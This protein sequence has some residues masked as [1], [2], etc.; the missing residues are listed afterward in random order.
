MVDKVAATFLALVSRCF[1]T[2]ELVIAIPEKD[3]FVVSIASRR[4]FT[5][6]VSI[7]LVVGRILGHVPGFARTSGEVIRV[8]FRLFFFLVAADENE[9]GNKQD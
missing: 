6:W 2:V 3:D 4:H 9:Y 8:C 5:R 7:R 1:S